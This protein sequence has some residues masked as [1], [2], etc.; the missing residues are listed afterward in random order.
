M[1]KIKICGITNA[2]D[3]TWVA[4]LGADYIGLVFTS[5]SSRSVSIVKAKE[6]VSVLPPYLEKVGLFVDQEPKIVDKVLKACALD[7]LQFHG[8]ERPEYC[9]QFKGGPKIIKAFRIKDQESLAV[10]DQYDCDFYLLDAFVE[11]EPGGTG[12]SFNWD[13][14][15]QV[16]GSGKQIFLAGGLN[17]E[18]VTEAIKK[19]AP[20][21]V[22]V[23]SGVE[24]SPRRKNVELMQEFIKKVRKF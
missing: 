24:S 10:I 6:I 9:N 15:V 23:S 1:I 4:N 17:P 22:D 5:Q 11:G 7:I 13:L 18:N 14:A 16:K 2:D 20:Y 8:A 19:V 12:E 21:A 3:A